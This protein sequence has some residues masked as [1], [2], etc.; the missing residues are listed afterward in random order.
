MSI[1]KRLFSWRKHDKENGFHWEN[2]GFGLRF[3]FPASWKKE[4]F[5][6]GLATYQYLVL[7]QLLEAG[8]AQQ[9]GHNIHVDSDVVCRLDPIS[10]QI[11]GLPDPWPGHFE[12]EI[13]STTHRP[14]FALC[15]RPLSAKGRRSFAAALEGPF[16]VV[17]GSA[18]CPMLHNG[19]PCMQSPNIRPFLRTNAV[20]SPICVPSMP[21]NKPAD[22]G[23]ILTCAIF[24][25]CRLRW[26]NASG[27][28][29]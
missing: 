26:H 2:T 27:S 9:S 13:H 19:W 29:P 8:E 28:P 21:Y 17:E 5:Q 15:L 4:R 12:L 3:R 22:R 7:Q 1:L 11:L 25:T 16:L 14:D 23:L 6:E 18:T 20:K 24:R 10:R